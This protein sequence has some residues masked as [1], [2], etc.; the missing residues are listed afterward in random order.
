MTSA[1]RNDRDFS[2]SLR[3]PMFWLPP[4]GFGNGVSAQAWAELADLAED[5]LETV[6]FALRNAGIAG[7]V[8]TVRT[9][10]LKPGDTEVRYRLWVD[11]LLYRHAE[12]LLME[13]LRSHGS[14][15][16]S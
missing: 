1:P 6:L 2:L 5:E 13:L 10:V 9:R 7:Y 8:A 14:D 3:G 15:T 12:D 16:P 11:S 4:H